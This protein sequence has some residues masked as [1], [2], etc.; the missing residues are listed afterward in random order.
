VLGRLA[1]VPHVVVHDEL[2]PAFEDVKQRDAA[3]FADHRNRAINLDHREPAPGRRDRVAFAR[4]R[5]LPCPQRVQFGLEGGP[6]D[7][8]GQ[9][10]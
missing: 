1:V 2:S 3:P 4:V 6:V 7:G 9:V 8:R 5:L 10:R